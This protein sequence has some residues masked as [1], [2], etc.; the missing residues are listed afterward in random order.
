MKTINMT[1]TDP[2]FRRIDKRKR[3]TKKTWEDFFL[4]LLNRTE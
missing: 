1:F 2:L 3:K 4:E